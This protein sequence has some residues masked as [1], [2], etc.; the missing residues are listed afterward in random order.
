MVVW[1]SGMFLYYLELGFLYS[2]TKNLSPNLFQ[3][4]RARGNNT[5]CVKTW[6]AEVDLKALLQIAL[7]L[8]LLN[9]F[10]VNWNA[11]CM[12]VLLTALSVSDL[13]KACMAAEVH[14]NTQELSKV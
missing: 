5:R 14:T 3:H 12:P 10:G 2:G 1:L 11:K 9:T 13:T 8:S 4:D 6:F 7:T